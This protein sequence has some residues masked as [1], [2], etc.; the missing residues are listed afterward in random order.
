MNTAVQHLS[1]GTP[2][3]SATSPRADRKG[4]ILLAAERLFAQYGFHAVSIR[5]IAQEAQVP[6]ALVGYHYG[7]KQ[8]LFHA[9][10]E[11]WSGTIAERL[12]GLQAVQS[13]KHSR[14]KLQRIV[15]AFISPVIKLRSSP[16]GE[17]YAM[18]MTKGLSPQ[19]DEADRVLRDFFDPMAEAFISAL[20]ETLVAEFPDAQVTLGTAAWSYQ[21]GL[22]VLLHHL[23]D[24]RVAR[25]SQGQC[26]PND[27]N[28]Q[29]HLV[30]FIVHGIRGAVPSFHPRPT[31]RRLS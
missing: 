6:L 10:F 20:H 30:Q 7:Q 28:V 13:Q 22:G 12:L 21:F 9:I 1:R 19:S 26:I 17:S 5:Q 27:P 31:K 23:S 24:T 11:H 15:E 25:L 8:D 4:Q 14:Q 16:E 18:L 29:T 2:R 3:N